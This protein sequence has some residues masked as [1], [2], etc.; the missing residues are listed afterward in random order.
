[1][2][3]LAILVICNIILC[4]GFN[5][6]IAAEKLAFE[7]ASVKP[8]PPVSPN[9]RVFFGP[10]Q[11]G[12]GTSDPTRVTWTY[13]RFIDLLMTAFD[14]KSYQVTGPSW[15]TTE[16]YDVT[17]KVPEGT[18]P[19]QLPAMWQSL[20]EERFGLLFH[21]ERKEFKVQE[22]VIAR[23]GS[24]LK[25][26]DLPES[27]IPAGPP[28]INNNGELAGPGMVITFLSLPS[29]LVA[30]ATAK[31]QPLS[32]LV[33][34][35]IS[36]LG[37]P[38]LDKTGL[39]GKFDFGLEFQPNL[40]PQPGASANSN[41]PSDTAPELPQAVERQLGLHLNPAKAILDMLIVDSSQKTP[42]SN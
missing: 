5:A 3:H 11:G 31:A 35:L 42:T 12:P 10:L 9:G 6:L 19:A 36:Q 27:E 37:M 30:R 18:T 29:G 38:V 26:T 39:A 22:L 15:I 33:T 23:G 2:R 8:S 14:V 41:Q 4:C 40:P 34:M 13:A 20:L 24:K 16:R 7:V 32:R 1:M 17:V 21:R 25:P 28:K